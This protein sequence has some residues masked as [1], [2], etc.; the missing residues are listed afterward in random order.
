MAYLSTGLQR[1]GYDVT[2]IVFSKGNDFYYDYVKERGVR[3]I[4]S[5]KGINR[6]RR[7]F[8]IVRYVKEIKPK[9]VIAYKDGVTMASCIARAIY[10]FKLIVSER[11]T[12]QELSKYEKLKFFLYNKADYI[13]PNSFSQGNF[14]NSH[15]KGLKKK[16]N[17]ITNTIDTDK[18]TTR[19][20]DHSEA[21]PVPVILTTARISPQKNTLKYLDAISIL[22]KRGIQCKFIWIGAQTDEYFGKVKNH[23][24][25]K[26]LNDI[27]SFIPPSKDIVKYYQMA[28]IFCLPSTYE[29]FPNVICEAMACGLP[30]A[31]GNVCDN[32]IIVQDLINGCLFDPNNPEDIADKLEKLMSDPQLRQNAHSLNADRIKQMCSN[33]AFISSYCN[34]IEH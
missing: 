11:N 34:L 26:D 33:D 27:V 15:Y 30:V 29:G 19:R 12:T 31:C 4:E 23:S 5:E 18:F 25:S 22:K 20:K 16:V 6:Y 1:K 3:L 13:V 9:A 7:A 32:P 17:V 10:P 8:E 28:D 2:L 14:I 21:N 24:D